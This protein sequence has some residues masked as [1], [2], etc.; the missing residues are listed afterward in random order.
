MA[1]VSKDSYNGDFNRRLVY[2]FLLA[3]V[4]TQLHSRFFFEFEATCNICIHVQV[5]NQDKVSCNIIFIGFKG[6][7][8]NKI[9]CFGYF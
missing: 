7:V 5:S 3:L 6:F 1:K 9:G 8:K 4:K 2:F